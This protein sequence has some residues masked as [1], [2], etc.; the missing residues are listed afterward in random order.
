MVYALD[1]Q[2]QDPVFYGMSLLSQGDVTAFS[3][4]IGTSDFSDRGY[5]TALSNTN[6]GRTNSGTSGLG[7]NVWNMIGT[8]PFDIL[9]N[10]SYRVG[11]AVLASPG[12][13]NLL[14]T[15]NLAAKKY[16]C[17][18][19][20][21]GP[22]SGFNFTPDTAGIN[23]PVIFSD[24]N[25]GT[26]IWDWD[27]GDGTS[28]Q[29]KNPSHV[30]QQV[31]N[32]NVTMVASDGSCEVTKSRMVRVDY[33]TTNIESTI[34]KTFSV[35]PN[36]H[37]GTCYLEASS[38]PAQPLRLSIFDLNGSV[39]WE[40]DQIRLSAGL[41]Y[42]IDMSAFPKG[43]YLLEIRSGSHAESLKLIQK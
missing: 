24:L 35:Y 12:V 34:S 7:A 16:N 27:F 17:N 15:R 18:V 20:Q 33:R 29:V 30:Y 13:N 22:V 36:P 25:P 10:S 5:F 32:Y 38:T 21:Q 43:M 3:G 23:Q 40:K 28:S 6:A 41:P 31:G 1:L 37:E 9:P 11:F 2:L 8:G 39:I 4:E 19:L 26:T 42:Q 14:V